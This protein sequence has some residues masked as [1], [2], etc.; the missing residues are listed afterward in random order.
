MKN[1]VIIASL[2]I[3]IVII[4]KVMSIDVDKQPV[5]KVVKH[6]ETGLILPYEHKVVVDT[7]FTN[8][9]IFKQK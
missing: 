4:A 5:K 1:I 3:N 8:E 2:I 9:S 6:T 7:T